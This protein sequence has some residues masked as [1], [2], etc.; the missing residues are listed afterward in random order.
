MEEEARA[1]GDT[2]KSEVIDS[3]GLPL[4]LLIDRSV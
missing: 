2:I 3:I 4:V 1:A